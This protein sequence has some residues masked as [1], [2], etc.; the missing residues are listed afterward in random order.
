MSAAALLPGFDDPVL[1]SQ[2]TFRAVLEAMSH[3]GRIVT[4]A[5]AVEA[6]APLAPAAAAVCLSLV[7]FETPLWADTAEAAA[8]GWLRFH[9]GCP[10]RDQPSQARFALITNAEAMP[11]LRELDAGTDE[12]PDRSATVIVQVPGLVADGPVRLTGPGIRTESRLGATGLPERFWRDWAA[13]GALYPRGVDVVL[14]S[15]DRLAA[16]PRTVKAEA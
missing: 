5:D 12:F 16:L 11:D 7:D 10:I 14:V 1:A 15:G 9:C 4:I 6:P 13:N 3:P 2:R 8:I